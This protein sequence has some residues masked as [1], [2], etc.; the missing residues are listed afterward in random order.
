MTHNDAMFTSDIKALGAQTL[1]AFTGTRIMM[2]PFRM[3]EP[4][5]SL[6]PSLAHYQETVAALVAM[7]PVNRGVAYITIDESYVGAGEHH[8]R[9]GLHVDGIGPDGK[10]G[11]WGGGGGWGKSGMLLVSNAYGCRAWRQDF[12]GAPGLNGDCAHIAAQCEHTAE[13][14]MLPGVVYWCGPLTVHESVAMSKPT[15]RQFVRLSM[16]S[17]APWY[18][19]YT[20]NPL[21]IAPTGPIHEPR[22]VFMEHRA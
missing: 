5:E 7:A 8:R 6:P 14:S 22:T 11:G 4:R 19:G 9:P 2:M 18:R 13:V 16:P 3:E 12:V 20:E 15:R 21:G 1:P 10:A 17:D